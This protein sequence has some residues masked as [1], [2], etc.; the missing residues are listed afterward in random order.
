MK[1]FVHQ[2]I[3]ICAFVA[4]GFVAN[5]QGGE[6]PIVGATHTYTVNA[7]DETNNGLVWSIVG[8]SS[9]DYSLSGEN[10]ETATITWNA[11]GNYTLRFV[12]TAN[13]TNCETVRELPITVSANTFDVSTT[14]PDATC[15]SKDGTV[16]PSGSAV[17][18]ISFVVSMNTSNAG[19]TPDWTFTF[20]LG[21]T[22]GASIADVTA[23]AGT[24]SEAS[25]VYTVTAIPNANGSVNVTMNVT[26]DIHT[27][28]GTT[29]NITSAT[30]LDYNLTDL[31]S[32]NWGATQTINP[33][34]NTSG[35]S[36][37]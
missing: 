23:S 6:T 12:E 33:L 32:N 15:N 2:L 26:G 5:A 18:S 3:A 21:T 37:N 27:A 11:T 29:L 17:T 20:T 13:G 14:D 4:V 9:G 30:E 25:G 1:K 19:W 31:T 7:E 36:A 28:L 22:G 24:L 10:S 16:N 34:P 8:G 35:I